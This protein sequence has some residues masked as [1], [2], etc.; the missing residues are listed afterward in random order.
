MDVHVH[1]GTPGG[2]ERASGPLELGFYVAVNHLMSCS[3][4]PQH[5]LWLLVSVLGS[6]KTKRR[7][8]FGVYEVPASQDQGDVLAK[9]SLSITSST[10]NKCVVPHAVQ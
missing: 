7:F 3:A 4:I 5:I 8:S 9:L 6:H 2:Q 10:R 1:A